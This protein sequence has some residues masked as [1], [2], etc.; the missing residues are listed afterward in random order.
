MLDEDILMVYSLS[1]PPTPLPTHI[2]ISPH[3]FPHTPIP[4][5]PT[6]PHPHPYPYSDTPPPCTAV[7]LSSGYLQLSGV[8]AVFTINRFSLAFRTHSTGAVL[9]QFGN[10]SLE[11]RRLGGCVCAGKGLGEGGRGIVLFFMSAHLV[12]CCCFFPA[13]LWQRGVPPQPQCH[14]LCPNP[15]S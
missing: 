13:S 11:V 4:L 15:L 3:S 7:K 6:S 2:P 12:H 8:G 1:H 10:A 5:L 9:A 14:A